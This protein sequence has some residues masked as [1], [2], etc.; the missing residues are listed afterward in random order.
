VLRFAAD[1]RSV[2]VIVLVS[3]NFVLQWALGEP[4]TGLIVLSVLLALPLAAMAH[5]HNHLPI[6]RPAWMNV[7]LGYWLSFFYG[8]PTLSWLVIHNWS[9]HT[10]GNLAG[11]DTTSTHNAGDRSDLWGVLLYFPASMGSFWRAHG[12]ALARFWRVS[13]RKFW[14][15]LSHAVFLHGLL[16]T[17][18]VLDPV[19]AILFVMVPQLAAIFSISVFNYCQHVRVESGSQYNVAR[20]FL[21]PVLNAYL[22]NVGYHTVHHLAP[23]LHWS[24]ARNEHERVAHHIDPRLNE[25]GFW[26]YFVHRIVTPTFVRARAT[27]RAPA[28]VP[29]VSS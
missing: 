9:H 13:R 5:N 24:L 28:S 12:R 19:K 1:W 22:F 17:L 27:G 25:R 11:K 21:S 10:H 26:P 29:P 23:R 15:Y 20:N 18:L 3:G 8:L 4:R 7:A 2:L 14:F 6:F 16:V